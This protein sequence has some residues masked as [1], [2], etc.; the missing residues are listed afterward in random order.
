MPLLSSYWHRLLQVTLLAIF[1]VF[2]GLHAI[3]KYGKESVM[4]ITS[5]RDTGVIDI[6]AFTVAAW[7]QESKNG[8]RNTTETFNIMHTIFNYTTS[9]EMKY[10][11]TYEKD[12]VFKDILLGGLSRE[13]LT[14]SCQTNLY[15]E[16]FLMAMDGR[17][18]R[19][20]FFG[21]TGQNIILTSRTSHLTMTLTKISTSTTHI[22]SPSIKVQLVYQAPKSFESITKWPPVSTINLL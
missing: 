7:N 17:A 22:S 11:N 3:K 10:W 2:F 19:S 13:S 20:I 15:I 14:N 1:F 9:D 16:D 21:T 6:P 8:W 4:V 18:L 5:E 12:E